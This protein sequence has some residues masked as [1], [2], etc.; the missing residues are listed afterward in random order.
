MRLGTAA[1]A[2]GGGDCGPCPASTWEGPPFPTL[3]THGGADTRLPSMVA[4]APGA[5]VALG[6]QQSLRP[7]GLRCEFCEGSPLGFQW[8]LTQEVG[9]RRSLTTGPHGSRAGWAAPEAQPS[10]RP[11]VQ[12]AGTGDKMP[13]SYRRVLGRLQSSDEAAPELGWLVTSAELFTES[14]FN[15]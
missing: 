9:R 15:T 4:V 8:P 2:G 5:D 3:R 7:Q 6:A 13:L 10:L 11:S 1:L 12:C 14:P